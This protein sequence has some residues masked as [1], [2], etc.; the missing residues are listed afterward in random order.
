MNDPYKDL[1]SFL[2]EQAQTKTIVPVEKENILLNQLKKDMH[3][4]YIC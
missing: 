2:V 1:K 4:K 3:I